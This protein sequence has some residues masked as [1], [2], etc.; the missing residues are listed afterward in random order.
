MS[1]CSNYNNVISWDTR[2]VRRRTISRKWVAKWGVRVQRHCRSLVGPCAFA[3][4]FTY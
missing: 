2:E 1:K 3:L 4:A